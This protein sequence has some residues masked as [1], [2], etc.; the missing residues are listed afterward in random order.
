MP[1]GGPLSDRHRQ[2]HDRGIQAHH[3]LRF[4]AFRHGIHGFLIYGVRLSNRKVPEH[5]IP[6]PE[7]RHLGT[8]LGNDADCHIA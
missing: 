6:D 4:E 5:P 2:R 7:T 1:S 3:S 8:D